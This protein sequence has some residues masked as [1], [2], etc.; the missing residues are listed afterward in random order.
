MEQSGIEGVIFATLG[1]TGLCFVIILLIVIF[2]Q[3]KNKLLIKQVEE[4]KNFER[5]IVESQ[6]EI[7]EQTLRN[8]S[9]ELHDNIGQLLTLAKI[10]LQKIEHSDTRELHDNL[11]RILNEVRAL[12]KVTNP[13]Y[14][15]QITLEDALKL[16]IE[17]FNRLNYIESTLEL[18]GNFSHINP[19]AEIIIFRILQ[20]FFSNT[21]KHSKA[22]KLNVVV[23]YNNLTNELIIEANDNGKGFDTSTNFAMGVGLLNMKKRASLIQADIKLNSKI[24]VGTNLLIVYKQTD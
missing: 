23:E 20:E 1:L 24:D 17:R 4:K 21:I 5:E 13:D 6:I 7:K 8:I 9:W 14:I 16:E 3:K 15:S 10:Q 12:S 11:T 18:K 2:Q 22:T 19:K